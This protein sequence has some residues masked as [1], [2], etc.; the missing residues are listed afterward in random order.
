MRPHSRIAV[1][2]SWLVALACRAA[3]AEDVVIIVDS[4]PVKGGEQV[5]G[6]LPRG[7]RLTVER[8]SGSYLLI[9]MPARQ[10]RGWVSQ[11]HVRSVEP[12]VPTANDRAI[13]E[14]AERLRS[15]I[16]RARESGDFAEAVRLGRMLLEA[17]YA[18]LG[19]QHLNCS[20]TLNELALT[21][22]RRGDFAQAE[23]DY[24]KALDIRVSKLGLRDGSNAALLRNIGLL[25]QLMGDYARSEGILLKAAEVTQQAYG[26]ADPEH[27]WSLN[28]LGLLYLAMGDVPRARPPLTQALQIRR[29]SL[30]KDHLRCGV[31]LNN[32]GL[33]HQQAGEYEQAA[34]LFQ[35]ALVIVRQHQGERHAEYAYCLD[36]L[37]SV[38]GMLRDYPRAIRHC[39]E[40][41]EILRAAVGD[42]HSEYAKCLNNLGVLHEWSGDYARAEAIGRQA[43]Q[44]RSQI[45]GE[46]HPETFVSLHNCGCAMAAQ[47][48][49]NDAAFALAGAAAGR[50]RHAMKVLPS[51]SEAEQLRFLTTH[52]GTSLTYTL[53]LANV[54]DDE[55]L[56]GLLAMT[57]LNAKGLALQSMADRGRIVRGSGDQR[58]REAAAALQSTRD[59]LARLTANPPRD[60]AAIA[61]HRN[62]LE[63]LAAEDERLSKRLG[64][65]TMDAPRAKRWTTLD[66]V[67]EVLPVGSVLIDF[68][69]FHP[70]NFQTRES[71]ERRYFAW[72]T[73]DSTVSP[74][75]RPVDL[76]PAAA[77]DAAV[78]AV[79]TAIGESASLLADAGEA[80]AER[81]AAEPLER[82]ARLILD[83]LRPHIDSRKQWYIS[84][85]ASLWLVP[86]EALPSGEGRE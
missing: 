7:T 10:T 68:A 45:F 17:Q 30:G 84:P 23:D 59:Q 78:Q 36:N 55:Q 49:W 37:G 8:R 69:A 6:H 52:L 42:R 35:E 39:S 41:R 34:K 9:T 71:E 66:P 46:E 32:L 77:I 28:A 15:Q 70:H 54:R 3:S 16:I 73:F 60:Q 51:L 85:D 22:V 25:W 86:W 62:R 44:L 14:Q 38:Y 83:P 79:Q 29:A 5:L 57:L 63:A 65:L 12:A 13:V 80:A 76:G 18:V 61:T 2:A 31:S 1:L 4:A 81:A 64:H 74:P 56:Q 20:A 50:S 43:Y 48:R 21:H 58:F 40:A 33:L 19:A 24:R 67:R 11:Q 72:L 75:V 27:A 26:D 82:L 53:S 47:A